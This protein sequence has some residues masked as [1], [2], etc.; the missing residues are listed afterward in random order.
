MKSHLRE[1]SVNDWVK[2]NHG[3]EAEITGFFENII[4]APGTTTQDLQ[5]EVRQYL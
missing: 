2:M 1:A 5:A 3:N 4:K